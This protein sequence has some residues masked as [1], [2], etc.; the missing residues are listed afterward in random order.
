MPPSTRDTAEEDALGIVRVGSR[1]VPEDLDRLD[2]T[3]ASPPGFLYWFTHVNQSR[4]GLR[5][6]VTSLVF[7]VLAGVLALLM[8]LQL[9]VP[10]NSLVSPELFNQ[11]FTMH[12]TTMMFLFAIPMVEGLGIYLA[13]LM[14]GTRDMAFPRLNAFGYYIYLIGGS[15]LFISLL[16]GMAPATGWFSYVPL[17]GKEYSPGLGPGFWA[18]MITF[19]EVSALTAAV[20]LVVTILKQR[21]PGMSLNRMPLFVWSIL[22]MALMIIFAM[23]AVI[24][25]SVM[26]ALDRTL[27]TQFFVTAAGGEPLLWQHLFWFFGH[28]EVYI[29]VVPALGVI[30][31]IIATFTQRPI[32]G[33]IAL[34]QALVAIG[35]VSFG[36]WVHHMFTV[37]LPQLGLSFFTAASAMIAIPSTVQVYCW[38]ASLWGVRV[39]FATPMLYIL[40]FFA[41]FVLGG[42]T[43]VMVASIPFDMQVHDTYFVVAHLHYVL[44]GGMVFPVFAGLYYWYPKVTGRMMSERLGRWSF[45]LA[46]VGFNMTFLPMHQLGLEG[47]PRR[48]Y[49]YLDAMGWGDVNLFVT[50]G[51]F[52]L[53]TGFLLT[54]WNFFYSLRR[55][56]PA[57]NNPWNAA[58]LE[59][60]TTSPPQ[61]CNF[62]AIPVV[63]GRYAN[64]DEARSGV[65]HCVTGLSE[66]QREVVVTTIM[67]AQPQA[68]QVLPNPTFWPF[69]AAVMVAFGFLGFMFYPIL[70]V[71][72]FFLTFFMIVGWLWPRRPW[73]EEA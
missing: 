34:V 6:I 14:I 39:R 9:A 15:V 33:Y 36:L 5:F 52:V 56:A 65:R 69:L 66:T 28:P 22:I 48:V 7:F 13:P 19:I 40:G 54:F 27:S 23:P 42:L 16:L 17:A 2:R 20:E 45:G 10:E 35:F 18:T 68:V 44:I 50:A 60:A 64:W 73:Q 47:M 57:G 24:V 38:I 62:P 61:N 1:T 53:A 63:Q 26:L 59:W 55:G 37:G 67:D 11:F 3:W 49:T 25:S 72:A 21:A 12:G 70:F 51:A 30:S 41:I 4:I 32:Y 71:V 46:F 8:R 31:T 29:I 43:G 58:T